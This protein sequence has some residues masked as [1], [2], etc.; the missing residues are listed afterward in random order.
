MSWLRIL[1]MCL[2]VAVGQEMFGAGFR[3]EPQSPA[4]EKLVEYFARETQKLEDACLADVR[5]LDDWKAK[6]EGYREE[7]FEML[8]LSPLPKRTDLAAAV[9]GKTEHPQ[10]TVEKLHFQ[11]MP[12]LQPYGS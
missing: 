9:T 8:S 4:D 11:S 7:L 6:R 3:L 12:R 2:V 5:T 1:P 10:F